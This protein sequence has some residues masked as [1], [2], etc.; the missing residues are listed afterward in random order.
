MQTEE[1]IDYEKI[2]AE[3]ERLDKKI[4]S[5]FGEAGLKRFPWHVEKETGRI[6]KVRN[7]WHQ[8]SL[9]LSADFTIEE[10]PKKDLVINTSLL[11]YFR[12]EREALLETIADNQLKIIN[13]DEYWQK[14][15]DII[16]EDYENGKPFFKTVSYLAV[17]Y[18]VLFTLQRYNDG[19]DFRDFIKEKIRKEIGLR[20]E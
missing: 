15:K 16:K 11:S 3:E 6:V 13:W 9:V 8:D 18:G 20:E 10:N 12:T 7:L 4:K 1:K 19:V 5:K 2:A 17:R 14:Y